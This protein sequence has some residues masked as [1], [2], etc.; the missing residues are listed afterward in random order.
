[1]GLVRIVMVEKITKEELTTLIVVCGVSF[2]FSS[3]FFGINIALPAIQK[4]FAISLGAIQWI[5]IMGNV[6][7]SSLSLCF[8]RLGDLRAKKKIYKIGV[9]L[10]TVGSGLCAL[11]TSFPQLIVFRIFMAVGLAMA[12]P[13]T[14]AILVSKFSPQRRG[15][16]L[17]LLASAMALGR[18]SG[19]SLGGLVVDLWNWRGIFLTTCLIGLP[20]TLA[21]LLLLKGGDQR[22]DE[23]FDLWGSLSLLI[24]YPALLI[25]LSLGSMSGWHSFPVHLWFG[26][27]IVGWFCFAVIEFRTE[28]PLIRPS[29]FR[30]PSLSV[31]MLCM[32]FTWSAFSPIYIF[33]PLYMQNVLNLS[34]LTAGLI[35][36]TPPLLIA[37]LSPISGRLADRRDGR[38]LITVGLCFIL[39]G[40]LLYSRSGPMTSPLWVG[41]ALSL[42]GIGN[43]LFIPANQRVA[44]SSVNEADY[45][46]VSAMLLS[47]GLASGTLGTTLA[48]AL[49]EWKTGG[50]GIL[51]DP[52]SF[53]EAQQFV[54]SSLLPLAVVAVLISFG[55]RSSKLVKTP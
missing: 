17:G 49:L 55:A 40:I 1:M 11:A 31:A 9:A 45:G 7:V 14:G 6:M 54:F 50:K 15:R 24:G 26:L 42:I 52:T 41:F 35:L 51:A 13:L 3:S 38:L 36:T 21:T 10:Y 8:G 53:A 37:V 48:V 39:F 47:F 19:P 18:I 16:G 2:L 25:A 46:V 28:K 30:L 43:G 29:F 32:V 4:E 5:S 33:A 44:F 22:R 27:S 20:V 23:P 34:P 12:F